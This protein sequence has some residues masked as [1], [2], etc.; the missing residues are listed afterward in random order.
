MRLVEISTGEMEVMMGF[1]ATVDKIERIIS[2]FDSG[3]GVSVGVGWV[4]GAFA[5]VDG[6]GFL[7]AL[8][9]DLG[10]LGRADFDEFG[11]GEIRDGVGCW[12][13]GC[14]WMV[15]CSDTDSP[16]R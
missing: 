4:G 14:R 15:F 6:G 11:C 16:S 3:G 10:T 13:L 8:L 5:E 7:V 1:R 2:G 9:V 12:H